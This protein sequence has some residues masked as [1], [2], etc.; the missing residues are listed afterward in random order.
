MREKL[1]ESLI[2]VEKDARQLEEEGHKEAKKLRDQYSRKIDSERKERLASVRKKGKKMIEQAE[3]EA[4]E[5]RKQKEA[6]LEKELAEMEER[7]SRIK[8]E[9]CTSYFNKIVKVEGE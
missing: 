7:F 4:L 3:K 8:D 9:V 6:D 2:Q 5:Y 1:I